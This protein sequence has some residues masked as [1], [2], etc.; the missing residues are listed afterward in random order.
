MGVKLGLCVREGR[1]KDWGCLR[2]DAEVDESRLFML[3]TAMCISK[4]RLSYSI[5]YN[6]KTPMF[7]LM[8]KYVAEISLSFQT[9]SWNECYNWMQFDE[10]HTIFTSEH[11]VTACFL[12]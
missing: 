7:N 5:I 10:I 8:P 1:N 2:K 9:E 6:R 12:L 4:L 3:F 11:D